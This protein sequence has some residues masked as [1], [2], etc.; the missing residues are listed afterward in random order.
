MH[1]EPLDAL[2]VQVRC[3]PRRDAAP[4]VSDDGRALAAERLDQ[5]GRVVAERSQVVRAA[6]LGAVV[7]AHVRRD[8]AVA[9]RRERGQLMAPRARELGEAVQEQDERAVFRPLGERL[10]PDPVGVQDH[11]SVMLS[12]APLVVSPGCGPPAI[13]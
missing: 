11:G 10:E 6:R 7:A 2:R 3:R 12:T 1:H 9:G 5:P 13:A 8:R 4:V